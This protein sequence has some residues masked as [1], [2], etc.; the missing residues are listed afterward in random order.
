MCANSFY[1]II[2]GFD[3]GSPTS[4]DHLLDIKK[5]KTR[6]LDAIREMKI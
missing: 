2:K 3:K 5:L 4:G 1:Y 6:L